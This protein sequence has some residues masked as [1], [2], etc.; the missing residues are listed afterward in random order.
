[1]RAAL[2]D[3]PS[4]RQECHPAPARA[5]ASAL[6]RDIGREVPSRFLCFPRSRRRSQK[7]ADCCVD[8]VPLLDEAGKHLLALGGEPVEPLIALVFF[9]PLAGEQALGLK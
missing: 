8:L 6:L 5:G 3:S 2:P 1:R 9:A 4:V 7:I